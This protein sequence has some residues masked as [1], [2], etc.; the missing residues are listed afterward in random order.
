MGI[1]YDQQSK[2]TKE[3]VHRANPDPKILIFNA[4]LIQEPPTEIGK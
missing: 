3:C 1:K 2:H 4:E